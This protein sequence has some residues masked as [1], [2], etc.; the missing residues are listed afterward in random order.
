MKKT[1]IINGLCLVILCCT[2]ACGSGRIE[3]ANTNQQLYTLV[4]LHPDEA[5][6]RMYSVN[7][8]R[9]GL[10]KYCTPV[11]IL[12]VTAKA[13]VIRDDATSKKYTYFFHL[14]SM[15]TNQQ[16]HLNK[17]FSTAC[18]PSLV[19]NMSE[20]DQA[21]IESGTVSVGMSK[22][23]VLIAIGYPPE[24]ETPTLDGDRWKYWTNRMATFVVVFKDGIVTDIIR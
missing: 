6:L 5:H 3:Y 24:H 23:G 2:F 18:D 20:E 12:K 9:E 14:K 8:Q 1:F 19:K 11:T 13:A 15:N 17:I 21:G 16:E 10:I 4:N 22:D 7:Y